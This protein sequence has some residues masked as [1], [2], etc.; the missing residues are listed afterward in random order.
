[1][2]KDIVEQFRNKKIS[3]K[4]YALKMFDVHKLL[5]EY[6]ELL[7]KSDCEKIEISK[8]GVLIK[9]KSYNNYLKMRLHEIDSAAVP[10]TIMSF[11]SY[12]ELEM[13][14]VLD[15]LNELDD[16]AVVFDIGA[17]LGWYTL[18]IIASNLKRKVYSFE[19]IEETFL[20]LKENL[21]LN[22]FG[23]ESV[24]NLGFYK[25]NR[26]MDFF[27][28]ITA[29]GAS[30]LANL[31]EE[32]TTRLVKCEFVMM[33]NFIEK[34]NI[35]RLDFI[36]CDVEGSE[37]FV[38]EG[39]LE[40]IRKFKPI[41]FS[42]MLRKWARKFGYH[43]NDIIYMFKELGYKCFVI[44]NNKLKEFDKVDENTIETNYF[45]LNIEKHKSIIEKY[46]V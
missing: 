33:D 31:R 40:S 5:L 43:P 15:L 4:E 11:G 12:E 23:S 18:N 36:K 24:Y 3:E 42:E 32:T 26:V 16:E 39:G 45:F 17:N 37:L 2:I 14:M 20:K 34:N 1:M 10:A 19:P 41:V 35:K 46:Q 44:Y 28:D 25:E 38:Y 27:Y 30:S 22:R 6:E 13:G 8:D 21:Y 7:K 29:S 9:I